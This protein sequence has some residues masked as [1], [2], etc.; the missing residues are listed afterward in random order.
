MTRTL[1]VILTVI[2]VCCL[3]YA[4]GR[5]VYD[6]AFAQGAQH[7]FYAVRVMDVQEEQDGYTVLLEYA[8]DMNFHYCRK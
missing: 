4:A 5:Y 7:G 3:L 1:T 6:S 8:N 2:L